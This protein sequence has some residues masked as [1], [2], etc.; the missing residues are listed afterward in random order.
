MK[1]EGVKY[2]FGV[3]GGGISPFFNELY[4]MAPDI[5]T[6]LVKHEQGAGFM[7][8][9][10]YMA[11]H[12]VA[13]CAATV[14]P[15]GMNLASGL[16]VAYQNS[17]PVLAI[18]NNVQ[19]EQFGKSGIQDACGWGPRSLEHVEAFE[20][21]TKWSV[22]LFDRRQAPEVTRRA[23]RIMLTDRKGP[24]HIDIPSDVIRQEVEVDRIWK[25][26]HYR[27]IGRIRGDRELVEKAADSL[28]KAQSPAILSGGGVLSSE[29]TPD[30]IE[31]AELLSIP[32]ATTLMGKSSFPED[33]PLALGVTGREGHDPANTVLRADRTDVLLGVGAMFHQCTTINWMPDFGG[34]KI[35]Q[36]NTD[37]GEIG[38]NY[39]ADIG[40]WGDAKAVLR[41]I[42]D[43]VKA[44]LA[45]M[46][47]NQLKELEDRKKERVKEILKLKDE[48]KYYKEPEMFSD[49][50]PLMPHRACREIREAAGKDAIIWTDCGN[51]LA[52]AER[53]IQA[54]G[55]ARTFL[56]DGGHTAMG[57]SV[58]ASIG[59]KL[60]FRDR[61][62][63]DITGN[64]AF[65]MLGKEI[66]TAAAY[67]IPVIWCILDDEMLGRIKQGQKMGYGIW[68]PE[69]YIATS[70]Y[71]PDFVK[72]AEACHCQGELVTRPGEVKEAVANAIK[73]GKPT[74]IDI[75]ID[76]EVYPPLVIR[77]YDKSVVSKYPYLREK[78]MPVPKWPRPYDEPLKG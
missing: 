46:P 59:S 78:K 75:K 58:A 70:S 49:V 30:L 42:T 17:V 26:E 21:V 35:I 18:T 52:W 76:P 23:F 69:R 40:I 48:L 65:Q 38:R 16:H 10:Y 3:P 45:K 6:I 50:V 36:V 28:I 8:T 25:P 77:A 74:V 47:K 51:N 32:V 33:H 7:A 57:F 67:D 2:L 71:D 41:E 55:P 56:V 62:V 24:V 44:E 53:Y 9:G 37:S 27:P 12:Q 1:S 4:D 19:T 31:L 29:A 73:S 54:I 43:I 22:L 68:E 11:S 13:S 66:T 63:I 20:P 64:A 61:V 39:P 60:A 14:G 5:K 72:L 15:G 34:Q